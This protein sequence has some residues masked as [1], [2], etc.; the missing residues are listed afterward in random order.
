MGE[1]DPGVSM[2]VEQRLDEL[3]I[4]VSSPASNCIP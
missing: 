3:V 2:F 1:E 4:V